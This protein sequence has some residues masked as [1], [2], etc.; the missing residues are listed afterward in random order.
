MTVLD[1]VLAELGLGCCVDGLANT[2]GCFEGVEYCNKPIKHNSEIQQAANCVWQAGEL[3]KERRKTDY[4]EKQYE[5][6]QFQMAVRLWNT[7]GVE[8]E[9]AHRE[10]LVSRNYNPKGVLDDLINLVIPKAVVGGKA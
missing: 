1:R 8:G 2:Y 9:A 5:H 7:K 3:I 4:V 6:I 10:D